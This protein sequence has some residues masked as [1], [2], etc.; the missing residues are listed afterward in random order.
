MLEQPNHC[1]ECGKSILSYT[2]STSRGI[3]IT[4]KGRENLKQI[5]EDERK[6][7]PKGVAQLEYV[8]RNIVEKC[9]NRD[10]EA[11]KAFWDREYRKQE[12]PDTHGTRIEIARPL[13]SEQIMESD[14]KLPFTEIS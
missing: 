11:R 9:T 4:D 1:T 10:E 2:K 5:I 14:G 13:T 6:V 3:Y 12:M 8:L 7:N